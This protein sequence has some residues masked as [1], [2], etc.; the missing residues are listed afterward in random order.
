VIDRLVVCTAVTRVASAALE[1]ELLPRGR[2]WN[3]SAIMVESSELEALPEARGFLCGMESDLPAADA[4]QAALAASVGGRRNG[5]RTTVVLRSP[6]LLGSDPLGAAD[7]TRLRPF[8]ETAIEQVTAA[9][10][11]RRTDVLVAVQRPDRLIEAVVSEELG[12]VPYERVV[13]RFPQRFRTPFDHAALVDRLREVAT[14]RSVSVVAVDPPLS[15]AITM[16]RRVRQRIID[17]Y[18]DVHRRLQEMRVLV[19]ERRALDLLTARG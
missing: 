17:A 2:R 1:R 7:L 3:R 15:P 9:L 11:P 13:E 10:A 16:S 14:V 4:F 19:D 5:R 6:L 8:A 12:Q 18:D